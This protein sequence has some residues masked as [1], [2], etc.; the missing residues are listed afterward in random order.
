M[1]VHRRP[2]ASKKIK[3][4]DTISWTYVPLD[5]SLYDKDKKDDG[6]GY[7]KP[8]KIKKDEKT[9][10]WN[11]VEEDLDEAWNMSILKGMM[12]PELLTLLEILK[13]AK[14]FSAGHTREHDIQLYLDRMKQEHGTAFASKLLAAAK[15]LMANSGVQHYALE[16][17]QVL[18]EK[19]LNIQQRLARARQMRRIEPKLQARHKAMQ[20]RMAD[21]KHLEGRARKA[22][23]NALRKRF[24]G[25]K[26]ANYHELSP[27]EKMSV[28][29]RLEGK[30][31]LVGRIAQRLMAKVRKKEMDRVAAMHQ[32]TNE[33]VITPLEEKALKSGISFDVLFEVYARG[34][35]EYN[36]NALESLYPGTDDQFAFD[37]V[38][39]FI[40]GGAARKLN[41]DLLDR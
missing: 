34:I 10:K 23:M 25:E 31:A 8:V 2:D 40:S 4:G 14:D 12:S 3:N 7:P 27:S 11:K 39:S 41:E 33:S 9:G 29:K 5:E 38:N 26:G 18:D 28:D 35:E 20:N 37:A 22:A 16:S 1:I 15:E 19:V 21:S 6:K 36:T 24:A 32:H 30:Q 17:V 13:R